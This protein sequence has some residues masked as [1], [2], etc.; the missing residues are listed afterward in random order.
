MPSTKF[1]TH[2]IID[3]REEVET[4]KSVA[5]AGCRTDTGQWTAHKLSRAAPGPIGPGELTMQFTW[6]AFVSQSGLVKAKGRD[7]CR[8]VALLAIDDQNSH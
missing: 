5:H 3:L 4:V 6:Y 2:P 1:G 7:G 8:V